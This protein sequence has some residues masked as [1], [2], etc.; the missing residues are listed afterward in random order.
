MTHEKYKVDCSHGFIQ[1]GSSIIEKGNKICIKE[2]NIHD[3]RYKVC[4][5]LKL[6]ELFQYVQNCLKKDLLNVKTI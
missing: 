3:W 1:K 5:S 6:K 4:K 2:L